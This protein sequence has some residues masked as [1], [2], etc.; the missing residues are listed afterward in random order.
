MEK[1]TASDAELEDR[2]GTSVSIAGDH[3]IVGATGFGSGGCAYIFKRDIS[4]GRW[5]QME[6][7]TAS[8]DSVKFKNFGTSVSI[9]G[10]YVIVGAAGSRSSGTAYIFERDVISGKWSQAEEIVAPDA[11]AGGLFGGAASISGIHFIVGG[12]ASDDA[13]VGAAYLFERDIGSGKWS[14]IEKI[15]AS[16]TDSGDLFGH[17]VSIFGDYVIIGARTSDDVG[18]DSGS[19]Y[20]YNINSL[21]NIS[22][23]SAESSIENES[24]S[25]HL[26][27]VI[28]SGLGTGVLTEEISVDI[29]DRGTGTATSGLDYLEFLPQTLTFPAGSVEGDTQSVELGIIQDTFLETDETIE[30]RLANPSGPAVIGESATHKVTIIDDDEV[31]EPG[32][33]GHWKFDEVDWE[34]VENEVVDSSGKGH[35]GTSRNGAQIQVNGKINGAG[36]LDGDN[37][38]IDLGQIAIGNPL[39][40]RSGGTVMG[41]FWQRDGDGGQR[42]VDKSDGITGANGYSLIAHSDDQS[43]ILAVDGTVFRTGSAVYKFDE[44][45]HVAAVIKN[46][47]YEIY[48]NGNPETATFLRGMA[49]FPP[50]LETNMHIGTWNHTTGR[51]FKGFL[52][53]IRI[54]NTA[55]E[56]SQ[57]SDIVTAADP[58]S[59]L[60][61]HYAFSEGSGC[62]TA[63][64]AAAPDSKEGQLE[65]D[66]FMN[67]PVWRTLGGDVR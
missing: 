6:K 53:D 50:N 28:L 62:L 19:A 37:D 65:P 27:S 20:I 1:I 41:W 45:T 25:A 2:F 52:D 29:I 48:V 49:Q 11:G 56:M 15:I 21:V 43:I 59:N 30:V 10:D 60:I 23:D 13:G 38:F 12:K 24:E 67:S 14:Q 58:N 26:V 17:S 9:S 33:V 35:H 61:A 34:G 22:F 54:Y 44:W 64:S 4:S 36:K 39:Q 46:G 42:I 57:I 55:L 32:L 66:C 18:Q 3:A 5:S 8:S 7:I 63:D 31:A 40:M 16:D 47:I 51:E